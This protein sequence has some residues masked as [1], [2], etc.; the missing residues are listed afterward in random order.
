M[1]KEL[2]T[3]SF[4]E[5]VSSSEYAVIDCYGDYCF[6]CE[7]LAPIFD[8]LASK[9]PG[10]DFCR[11]NLSQ[12]FELAEEMQIFSFPTTLFYKKGELVT[13]VIGSVEEETLIEA[14]S[15]ILYGE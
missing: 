5:T 12:N 13:S 14:V 9:M 3:Q 7:L 4:K 10:V 6:A 1:I 15:Q 2:N 8:A 11:I